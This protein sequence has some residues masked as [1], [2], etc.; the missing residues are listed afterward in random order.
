MSLTALRASASIWSAPISCGPRTLTGENDAIG[1]DE[2][3]DTRAHIGA[4]RQ[5]Q[6]HDLVRNSIANLVRMPFRHRFAGK[7]VISRCHAHVLH[8]ISQNI[9]RNRMPDR[10]YE[11]Q[12]P[13]R[14]LQRA[15]LLT[16]FPYIVKA[17]EK[18]PD[19][20]GNTN[21]RDFQS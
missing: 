9:I 21:V 13:R 4:G 5:K 18:R 7:K 19:G 15:A 14:K 16:M 11:S 3:F 6:I 8:Q 10:G 17:R 1:R 12:S 2:R 20:R